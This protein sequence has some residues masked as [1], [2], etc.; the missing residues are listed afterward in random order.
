MHWSDR[1]ARVL[2][3]ASALAVAFATGLLLGTFGIWP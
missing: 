2:L 3:L 1:L